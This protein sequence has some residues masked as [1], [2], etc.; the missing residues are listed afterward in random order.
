MPIPWA[1]LSGLAAETAGDAS[2]VYAIYDSYFSRSRIYTMDVSSTPALITGEL[3]IKD[4]GGL[5]AAALA[6]LKAAL[7]DTPQF[8]PGALVA[9]DGSVNLD[10]EGIAVGISGGFW[11]AS[12][13]AGNLVGGVS[14]PADQPFRSPNVLLACDRDGGITDVVLLPLELTLE[15]FRFGF[16]GVAAVE[17]NGVEVLYVAFQRR[18]TGAGDPANRARIGRYDT[19]SGEWTFAYYPLQAPTSPNGGWVGLSEITHVGNGVFA[20]IE[21]DNQAGP[22]ATIKRVASFSI[23]GVTFQPDAAAPAF[24]LLSKTLDRDL[25]AQGDYDAGVILEKLEGM[26]L[27]ADGRVIVVND[28][29]G[30]DG[31]NGET[32]I[33]DL[34]E[35]YA[36]PRR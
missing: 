28:N 5:L 9:D 22:D 13:G 16:E 2:T 4:T 29:D 34:G 36:R 23:A 15:Q 18:W 30:V 31:S 8:D 27:L 20:V 21:R 25:I 35:L 17:E 12:E 26:A 3:E 32:R 24:P 1:A 11:V 6:D 7:P 14:N 10:P 33:F 19:S